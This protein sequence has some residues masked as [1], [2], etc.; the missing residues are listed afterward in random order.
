M[1]TNYLP[2]SLCVLVTSDFPSKI[3]VIFAI[4][5]MARVAEASIYMKETKRNC[6]RE[7]SLFIL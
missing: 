4:Y 5:I 7:R 1:R 3:V 2:L 6:S